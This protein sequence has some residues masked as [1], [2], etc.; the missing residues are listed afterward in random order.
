VMFLVNLD[1]A[2]LRKNTGNTRCL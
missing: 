1:E 2:A